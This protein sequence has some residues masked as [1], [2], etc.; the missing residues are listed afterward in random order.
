MPYFDSS[1]DKF[2]D[3]I[4]LCRQFLLHKQ[5]I[6]KIFLYTV[7]LSTA[8]RIDNFVGQ[9]NA[10]WKEPYPLVQL[11]RQLE[12]LTIMESKWTIQSWRCSYSVEKQPYFCCFAVTLFRLNLL[13]TLFVITSSQLWERSRLD[14]QLSSI[15]SLDKPSSSVLGCRFSLDG[16]IGFC[17]VRSLGS[18]ALSRKHA[19]QLRDH[20]RPRPCELWLHFAKCFFWVSDCWTSPWGVLIR[21]CDRRG[22]DFNSA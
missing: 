18:A 4:L 17:F 8:L 15:C 21:Q 20:E 13:S 9:G 11:H 14:Y 19:T 6:K 7:R 3:C 2:L 12:N 22:G 16:V 1:N 5:T 10:N